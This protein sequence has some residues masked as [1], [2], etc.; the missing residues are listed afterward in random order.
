VSHSDF[1]R[2]Q[3]VSLVKKLHREYGDL[4]VLPSTDPFCLILWEQVAY[5]ADDERRAE[6]YAQLKARVGLTPGDV[7]E[8]SLETLE[9]V[10]RVGGAIA[11]T[12]RATRMQRTA[13]IAVEEW[14]GDLLGVLT[15]PPV[16]ARRTLKRFPMIGE[17]GADK[18]LMLTRAHPVLALDSN[19]LRVLLRVGCGEEGKSYSTTYRNVQEALAPVIPPDFDWLIA[20]HGL[21]RRHGQ[22]RCKHGAPRCAGCCLRKTCGYVSSRL[23]SL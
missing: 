20:A 16:E 23:R 4:P 6:A 10:A 9:E 11:V 17:P 15:L 3:L 12:D 5:L 18:I 19:G 8:A 21:L 1:S 14:A 22:V 13:R 7:L 2:S